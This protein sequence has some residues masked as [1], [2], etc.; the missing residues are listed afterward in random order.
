MSASSDFNMLRLEA[1]KDLL[2]I[3]DGTGPTEEVVEVANPVVWLRA[4]VRQQKQA[5]ADYRQLTELC[6]NA[7]DHTDQRIQR[8][9]QAYQ[10]LSDG[11][12]YVYD[13]VSANEEVAEA[14]IRSE[15]ATAANAYQTFARG[16]WQAIIERTNEAAQQQIGQATQLARVNDALAFQAAANAAR[17]EHLATFQGN[18]ELWATEH[19]KRVEYME[20]QLRNAQEAIQRVATAI[21]TAASPAPAW[22]SPVR[23]PSTSAPTSHPPI[24]P[25]LGSP[26]PIN[27][28]R[29]R[30]NPLLLPSTPSQ[31]RKWPPAIPAT[32]PPLRR[33]L[34]QGAGG[35]PSGPPSGPA[36]PPTP[37]SP[38]VPFR[39]QQTPSPPRDPQTRVTMQELIRLVAE[40]VAWAN[41][42]KEPRP[43]RINTSRLK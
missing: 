15:L 43:E 41:Q 33:P 6:G 36:S 1:P 2:Q 16:V 26:F 39:R 42:D 23:P 30:R 8:I 34:A 21:P 20:T 24:A 12:R 11:T 18:V 28:H 14:W 25:L 27:P 40:G 35:P 32:P 7:V 29:L 13:R 31:R 38:R 10:E 22:R 4:L 9:E 37:P 3:T 5:E 17:S 19:Q